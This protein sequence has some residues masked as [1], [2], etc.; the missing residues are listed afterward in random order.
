MNCPKGEVKELKE[1]EE[2]KE[3]RREQSPNEYQL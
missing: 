3:A 2:V 1:I